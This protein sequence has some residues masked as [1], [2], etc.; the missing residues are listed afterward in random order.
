MIRV[1]QLGGDENVRAREASGGKSRLQRAAYLALVPVSFRA[2]EVAES[3]FERVA[4]RSYG[5]GG[6]GN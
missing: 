6:V 2:I 3:G 5:L 1:P 4:G